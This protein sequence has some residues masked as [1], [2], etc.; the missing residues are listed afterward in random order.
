MIKVSRSGGDPLRLTDIT[1]YTVL[2]D[3]ELIERAADALAVA[4]TGSNLTIGAADVPGPVV[5]EITNRTV[6]LGIRQHTRYIAAV[7]HGKEAYLTTLRTATVIDGLA[8][9]D[10][11]PIGALAETDGLTH[12]LILLGIK[13]LDAILYQTAVGGAVSLI[14]QVDE[15]YAAQRVGIESLAELGSRSHLDDSGILLKIMN[16]EDISLASFN[17]CILVIDNRILIDGFTFGCFT[18]LDSAMQLQ[19]D[20]SSINSI[21]AVGTT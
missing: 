2:L 15:L 20:V 13:I 14:E 7:I 11:E 17:M 6:R 3:H 10:S 16:I 1:S 18:N 19:V 12:G 4:V 8:N 5:G 21:V 9:L